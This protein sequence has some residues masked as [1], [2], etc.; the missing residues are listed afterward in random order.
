MFLDAYNRSFRLNNFTKSKIM[1]NTPLSSTDHIKI[2]IFSL[3]L[4]PII[5]VIAG[6]LPTILLIF[7]VFMMK[8]NGDFTH[9]TT[10]VRVVRM[11]IIIAICISFCAALYF[12]FEHMFSKY[13]YGSSDYYIPFFTISGLGLIYLKLLSKLYYE[14]LSQHREWVES[15]GIFSNGIKKVTESKI[16]SIDIIKGERLKSF[17]VADELIKWAQLKADG[18]ITEQEYAEARTK[19]LQRE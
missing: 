6:I 16:K 13:S 19:L 3:L 10:T 1:T 7:G 9:I 4:V 14:P 11:Y 2:F 15:N 18:H 12:S 5:L 17:S 8:K